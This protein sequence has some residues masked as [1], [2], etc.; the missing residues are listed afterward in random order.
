MATVPT[1]LT[2]VTGQIF[3][4]AQANGSPGATWGAFLLGVPKA[5]LRQGATQ[6]VTTGTWTSVLFDAEDN[7]SDNAH[8]TI[9]ST[10]RYTAQTAGWLRLGGGTAWGI[11]ATGGRLCRWAVNGVAV[12]ASATGVASFGAALNT[13]SGA[14]ARDVQVAVGDYVE[15]QVYQ[16]SGGALST[17]VS[18]EQACS[19][20]VCWV[21]T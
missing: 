3:T 6:S 13:L 19:M 15:L 1:T 12:N 14:M 16:S 17:V 21:G 2:Y 10:S 20:T 4:A 18:V 9:T 7:D 5:V 8:S 11:N